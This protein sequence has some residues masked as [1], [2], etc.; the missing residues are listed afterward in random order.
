MA[1]FGPRTLKALQSKMIDMGQSRPYING[2]VDR[3]R[4]V[5]KWGVAQEIVPEPVY[6]ALT[7]VPGLRKGHTTAREPEPVRPV[8]E[9]VVDA[10]LPHLPVVVADMVRLQRFTGCRADVSVIVSC[11]MALRRTRII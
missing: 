1:Q 11:R 4:R 6:R 5:F 9:D 8:P 3:I 7:C 2:N 10:T